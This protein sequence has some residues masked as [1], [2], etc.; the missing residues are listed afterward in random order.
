MDDQK[1][2]PPRPGRDE[3]WACLAPLDAGDG[4]ALLQLACGHR[5]HEAC[6][7][8]LKEV[9]GAVGSTG[10]TCPRCA[11]LT[12][13]EKSAQRCCELA[14]LEYLRALRSTSAGS[15]ARHVVSERCVGHLQ[16]AYA[17]DPSNAKAALLFGICYEMGLGVNKDLSM[18]GQIFARAEEAGDPAA[19]LYLGRLHKKG[20]GVMHDTYKARA[21]FAKAD[22]GGSTMGT[23]ELALMCKS[24]LGGEQDLE[25]ARAL[26]A[27]AEKRGDALGAYQL[28]KM[29]KDGVG[30]PADAA[31]ARAMMEKAHERDYYLATVDLA[32]WYKQG[33]GGPVDMIK[34]NQVLMQLQFPKARIPIPQATRQGWL[35]DDGSQ[36]MYA[37]EMEKEKASGNWWQLNEDDSCNEE[38]SLP[39]W[40]RPSSMEPPS[41]PASLE[42]PSK[43]AHV[44]HRTS[45]TIAPP[46]HEGGGE[47]RATMAFGDVR[48][49][50][51]VK[52]SLDQLA[53]SSGNRTVLQI[54]DADT[55]IIAEYVL[56]GD[57]K[58]FMS[59]QT[60][61]P[62][63]AEEQ[64]TTSNKSDKS[65]LSRMGAYARSLAVAPKK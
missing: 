41:Q 24:G 23:L 33:I 25:R 43:P 56:P 34:S 37:K 6:L 50:D 39:D 14:A 32:D 64:S 47:W 28:A 59:R 44:E 8:E 16:A 18:A 17:M 45:S 13:G 29:L 40:A 30:G 57:L 9:A 1:E 2:Q 35:C 54:G 46:G 3:C 22:A 11:D 53:S 58:Q 60:D 38:E 15:P 49:G 20:S 26:F 19:A 31:Q 42:A 61:V 5:F 21:L 12:Q 4:R 7:E 65:F 27:K 52:V 51:I 48:Y 55:S 63:T 10:V 62:K 36:Q